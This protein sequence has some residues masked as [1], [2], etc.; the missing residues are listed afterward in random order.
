VGIRSDIV[1][2]AYWWADPGE[3]KPSEEDLIDF[4]KY[5]GAEASPSYSEASNAL[6]YR[7]TGVKV[8]GA[9][10]HWCGIFACYVVR[11][12][13][14]TVARWTLNGGKIYNL[15]LNWGNAGMQPGDIAMIVAGNHHFIVT[16]VDYGSKTMKTVEGNTS[17]Q[18]IRSRSRKTTEPYAY[19]SI[20]G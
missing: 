10:K 14:I 20:S 1:D 19:Y 5:S 8:N 18:Y 15:S 6:K 2:L 17:G 4:F 7:D 16:D 9:V 11:Q 12:A 13:G 3:W